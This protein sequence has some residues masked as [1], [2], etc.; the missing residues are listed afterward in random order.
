MSWT[1]VRLILAREIRDQLRDRR[2]LFMMAVLPILLYPMLGMSFLQIS[3]F[4]HE[5]PVSVAVFGA[6]NL[7]PSP[8]L[9]DEEHFA[10]SLFAGVEQVGLL[11]VAKVPGKGSQ[12]RKEALQ[13]AE[14][15]Q[16]DAVVFVP[17]DFAG[18]LERFHQFLS[19]ARRQGARK[20]PPATPAVEVPKPEVFWS[21]ASEKS[22]VA[23]LRLEQVLENWRRQI[24]LANLAAGGLPPTAAEPFQWRK[25]DVAQASGREVSPFWPKLLPVMMLVWALTGAFYPAVDL[26]AGEK[27]RGTLE[28]LLS[29]PA[30]RGEIV[31]G[32]LATIMLFSMVTALLNVLGMGLTGWLILG[33]ID[34]IG[35]PPVSAAAWLLAAL[36]PMSLLFSALCLAVAAFARSS[37][38]GQYYLMPLLLVTMPL[39]VL[40]MAPGVELNLGYSL[41]PVTGVVLL[42][43]TALEGQYL[44]MLRFAPPVLAVTAVCALLAIRWAIDQFNSESV[45]FRES[46]RLDMGLWLHH[47]LQDRQPT[48]TVAA[49]VFCGIVIL[50]VRFFMTFAV[51]GPGEPGFSGLARQIVVMELAVI[52]TPTLLMTALFTYRPWQT[53]GLRRPPA[54]ALAA[55]AFLAVLL[56]PLVRLLGDLVERL[57]PVS[58]QVRKSLEAMDQSLLRAPYWQVLL[59]VAVLPAVCEELAFRGFILSGLRHLGHKWRAIV[60]TAIF[61]GLTHA[62]LQQ[63]LV[64]CLLGVV[65]GYLAVQSN[66]IFP[67]MVFHVVNNSLAVIVGRTPVLRDLLTRDPGHP[68]Q[69]WIMI[70]IA[71]LPAL[72]LLY[73]FHRLPW[74]RSEEEERREAILKAIEADG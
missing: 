51:S 31:L 17:A 20:G 66:S 35:P 3:Q 45:L 30:A 11:R 46:E 7:P 53:L 13:A 29:S 69:F 21:K 14:S 62:I 40:P 39:V 58:E 49:A 5:H 65:I 48:P 16:Y 22:Q 55:A 32:K 50:L 57:Y 54:A 23:S 70:A 64:A 26:C 71:T 34:G 2:T 33:Q 8:R 1:N 19:L 43:K 41:I 27:E 25:T 67:G 6:E 37:K 52:L 47:L 15:G 12:A 60:Y 72:L 68:A 59:L 63:S 42:L 44:L 61:F 4:M 10:A 38:E 28:T 24:V 74:Q 56:H 9:I 36:V 73:G 18:Q